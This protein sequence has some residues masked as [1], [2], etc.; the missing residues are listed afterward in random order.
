[1]SSSSPSQSKSSDFGPIADALRVSLIIFYSRRDQGLNG[2]GGVNTL[3]RN[4]GLVEHRGR[5]LLE[6]FFRRS[7]RSSLQGLRLLELGCGFGTL[8][9][10]FAWQGAEVVGVDHDP[11]RFA[12]GTAVAEEQG[13]DLEFMKAELASFDLPGESFDL[14]VMDNVFLPVVERERRLAVLG[15]ARAVLRPGGSLLLRSSN[16]WSPRMAKRLGRSRGPFHLGSPLESP[17]EIREAGFAEVHNVA[18]PSRRRP[19]LLKP[20]APYLHFIAQRSA[21]GGTAEFR[22][23]PTTSGRSRTRS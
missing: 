23:K 16:R 8:A 2:T 5:S 15:R 7:G 4:S 12:I 14:V 10:Y 21:V 13:L 22:R 6:I 3:E 18:P 17:R 19:A 20:I 9:V 1:V 11:D